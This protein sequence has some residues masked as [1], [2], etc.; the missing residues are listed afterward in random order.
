MSPSPILRRLY[1]FGV[2][3]FLCW[4][5][6]REFHEAQSLD[7]LWPLLK[8]QWREAN[9]CYL[10]TAILLMPLNWF[11]EVLKWQPFVHRNTPFPIHQAMAAVWAGVSVSL[12][13]PNRIGEYGGRLLF[14]P[15]GARWAA[16]VAHLAGNLSQLLVL[17]TAGSAGALYCAV[18][19]HWLPSGEAKTIGWLLPPAFG[20]AHWI[21]FNISSIL[22]FGRRLPLPKWLLKPLDKLDEMKQF[23]VQDLSR[24]HGWSVLRYAIYSTQY[25]LL[26]LFFGVSPDFWGGFAGIFTIFLIQAGLPLPPLAGLLARGVLAIHIWS[27]FGA[28]EAVSLA[29]TFTLWIINLIFAA[30]IGT[31]FL[32]RVN[33]GKALSYEG[34]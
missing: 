13:T 12:F 11:C 27:Y 19:F 32:L 4:I 15:R 21:F 31:F 17:L 23:S 29:A 14:V 2:L 28:S 24:M 18:R 16:A 6:W 9:A 8:L 10:L 25:Y 26:L 1:Q 22:R 30:L 20:L 7:T 33:I 3:S 34:D 5:L